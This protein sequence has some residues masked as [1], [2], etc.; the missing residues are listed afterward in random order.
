MRKEEDMGR[1]KGHLTGDEEKLTRDSVF[2]RKK[3][4]WKGEGY[5]GDDVERSLWRTLGN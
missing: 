4:L 1:I 3:V 5:L 2:Q